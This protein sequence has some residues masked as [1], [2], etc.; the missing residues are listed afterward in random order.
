ME[1][2]IQ[3]PTDG[4]VADVFVATGDRVAQSA[5]LIALADG[6]VC[7]RVEIPTQMHADGE[8]AA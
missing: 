4:V 3:A 8:A 1:L 7:G 5:P 2:A 6:A